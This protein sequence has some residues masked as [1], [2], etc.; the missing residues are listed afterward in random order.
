[1][2]DIGMVYKKGGRFYLAIDSKKLLTF[3]KGRPVLCRGRKALQKEHGMSVGELCHEWNIGV[4]LLDK[5]VDKYL[6]QK[7]VSLAGAF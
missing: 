3:M 1:M 4:T 7:N 2:Y 5:V 6:L